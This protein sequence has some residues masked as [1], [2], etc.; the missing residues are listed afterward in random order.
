[1]SFCSVC[2]VTH[3]FSYF[4]IYIKNGYSVYSAL[5]EIR[6]FASPSLGKLL[7]DL[8][9]ENIVIDGFPYTLIQANMLTEELRV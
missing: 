2:K 9:N 6:L 3:L 8:V 5:K 4:K 7:E 1:M